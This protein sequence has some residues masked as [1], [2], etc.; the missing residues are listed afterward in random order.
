MTANGSSFFSP[1]RQLQ[2]QVQL[3]NRTASSA[4][5]YKNT[6]KKFPG[7]RLRSMCVLQ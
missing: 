7:S 6:M 1:D 4:S 2:L 5:K 3:M